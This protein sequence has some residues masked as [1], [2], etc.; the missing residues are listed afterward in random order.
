MSPL[1]RTGGPDSI[2]SVAELELRA[3]LDAAVDGVIVIDA[4][5]TIETFSGAAERLFGYTSAEVV[6]RNVSVLMPDFS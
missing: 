1:T 3:V 5:G 4:G 2:P 6:G